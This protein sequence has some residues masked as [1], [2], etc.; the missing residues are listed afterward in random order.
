[1]LIAPKC[2]LTFTHDHDD[3][4]LQYG[5]FAILP[6]AYTTSTLLKLSHHHINFLS[7]TQSFLFIDHSIT[8]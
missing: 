1:M 4:H 8:C 7:A 6:W 5:L 2:S 3:I